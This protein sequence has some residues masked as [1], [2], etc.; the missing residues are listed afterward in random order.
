MYNT[1]RPLIVEGAVGRDPSD[2]P[3]ADYRVVSPGYFDTL[4]IPVLRGRSLDASDRP[5][6]PAVAVVSQSLATRFWP[7]VDPVGR[8]FRTSV[9]A[10]WITVVGV[11]GDVVHLIAAFRER[12]DG[13]VRMTVQ[14]ADG[15]ITEATCALA[16]E[17]LEWEAV[18][19]LASAWRIDT[20]EAA[21]PAAL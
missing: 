8:R 10:P 9:D 11:A 6:G 5:D 3:R 2:L 19:R 4:R 21:A 12:P 17:A 16:G 20:L 14:A 18:A 15:S 13:V 1:S 7:G